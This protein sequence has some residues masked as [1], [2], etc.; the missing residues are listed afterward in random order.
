MIDFHCHLDLYPNPSEMADEVQRRKVGVLSV[1]TTPSA[2]AGT[3]RLARDRTVIRTALGLHPQLAGERIHELKAFDR[4]VA[5][6]R[7][8]GEVGLDGAPECRSFWS[9]QTRV[10]EHILHACSEA[11]DKV[12][13]VHSRRA[14]TPV[15]DLLDRFERVRMP[16]LHWFSGSRTELRRAVER[17]CWFS[18]GPAMLAGAKGRALVAAMPRERVLLETDGPFAQLRRA[19]L[20]PWDV[21][22][23]CQSLSEVWGTDASETGRIISGNESTLLAGCDRRDD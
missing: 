20:Q 17:D 7:F 1:T 3:S 16:I 22:I 4:Y 18:V 19:A 2:W 21:A 6:T 5:D 9:Q 10:F 15:L 14:A 23:A 11:G 13:S 8:I 12:V